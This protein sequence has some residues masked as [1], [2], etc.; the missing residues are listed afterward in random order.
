MEIG[1]VSVHNVFAGCQIITRGDFHK[2]NG[3]VCVGEGGGGENVFFV[4]CPS[5][6]EVVLSFFV[7]HDMLV[8]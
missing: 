2:E 4:F 5:C 8:A 1:F 7:L 3:R 6:G